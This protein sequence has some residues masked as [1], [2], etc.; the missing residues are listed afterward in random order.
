MMKGLLLLCL[1]QVVSFF[2]Y[3]FM[4]HQ[5]GIL[6]LKGTVGDITFYKSKEG[7]LAR[8]KGGIDAKRIATDPAFQRTRENGQEFGRA[9]KAGKFLRRAVRSLLK[10][11]SDGK[12]ISRLTRQMIKVIQ[13]DLVNTRGNR[14]II[15]GEAE[16]LEGFEF[17][18]EANLEST[19]TAPFS[20]VIDRVTGVLTVD[21]PAFVPAEVIHAPEGA[22]HFRIISAGTEV[23]F[24]RGINTTEINKTVEMP[25][26]MVPTAAI[27]HAHAVTPGSVHPLFILLGIEFLQELNGAM[28]PLKDQTFNALAI[29][30]VSGL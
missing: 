18:I 22:N 8:E 29:I 28:Y 14:N 19:L 26:D 23:D 25:L 7:Y 9:G 4:A 1:K 13:A 2:K 17:N 27:S 21:I 24:E 11:T 30:K 12:M 15:D 5:K 3:Y 6:K 20:A 16:L 10:N